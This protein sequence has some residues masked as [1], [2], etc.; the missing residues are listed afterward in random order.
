M[1][2]RAKPLNALKRKKGMVSRSSISEISLL[3]EEPA[4]GPLVDSY[5]TRPTRSGMVIFWFMIVILLLT[6][7]GCVGLIVSAMG[8]LFFSPITI[9]FA[10]AIFL[11][12]TIFIF[13][14]LRYD[15]RIA[16]PIRRKIV[17]SLYVDGFIYHEGRKRQVIT[18]EQI[19]FIQRLVAKQKKTYQYSYKLKLTDGTELK[20][21]P[22]I[23]DVQKLG[24]GI[25]HAITERLLSQMLADYKANKPIVFPCLC[26]NQ[27]CVSKSE[28]KLV[29]NEVE[30]ITI[31]PENL[32][33]KEYGNAKDWL[34]APIAQFPN[35]CVLEALMK[36]IKSAR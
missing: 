3:N 19:R 30:K 4:L 13:F 27:Y 16:S 23:A 24:E 1:I 28:E 6:L 11:T 20:L 5:Q 21:K 36:V 2:T 15:N 34:S 10:A 17:V 35:V 32:V 25:E 29:W 31:G 33:I 12:L 22:L 9:V 8:N 26:L 18:W 14:M 7:A